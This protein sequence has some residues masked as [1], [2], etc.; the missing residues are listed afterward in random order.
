M[1]TLK[2]KNIRFCLGILLAYAFLAMVFYFAS[3][4][5]L[6]E[7]QSK[8]ELDRIPGDYPLQ[9]LTAG[10]TI[11]QTFIC[12]M[13]I[14]ERFDLWISTFARDNTG[15]I[16]VKL[17]DETTKN[18]EYEKLIDVSMLVDSEQLEFILGTPIRDV[19]GHTLSIQIT[20]LDGE[21]GNAVSPWYSSKTQVE[22]QKLYQLEKEKKGV[23]T[24]ATYGKDYVWTGPHY[25]E[26]VGVG[27]LV[28]IIYCINLII[29]AEKQKKSYGLILIYVY[30]KYKFLIK[31][32]VSRD[33]KIKYKRSVLGA[34]WSFLNPLLMMSVQYVVFSTIFKA[35]IE[36]Y[37]VYLLAGIVLFNFFSEATNVSIG[38]IVGNASLITKVYVPKYIYPVSKVLSA[39]INLLISM[40]PLLIMCL[41]TGV[42]ITKAFLV[43][44]FVIACLLLFCIGIGFIL[45]SLMVFFR[46]I[47][48]IWSVFSLVW[49]YATPVFYPE[50]ILPEGF[51]AILKVN[52]MYYFIKF[53]RIVLIEGVVPE[54]RMFVY[55]IISTIVPL[56]LGSVLFKKTQD[57][58]VFYI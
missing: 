41:V 13:D 8:Y 5:Q 14:I 29:K 58:F 37:P 2:K 44:P 45:S 43:L 50:S 40:F 48:F 38:A 6:F 34:F 23:L 35:D 24:F 27:A 39:S 17:I 11:K 47:Q 7:R 53:F 26:L 55:C 36:N 32:L 22:G 16:N 30:K 42:S 25:W 12:E 28:L 49:M 4:S 51:S 1:K 52:P 57:K 19:K 20:S 33:F 10:D 31:Q 46:D 21:I 18:V 15:T 3:G 54:P 56:V 9:E